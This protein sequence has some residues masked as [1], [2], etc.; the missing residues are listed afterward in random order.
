[1]ATI[2]FKDSDAKRAL[3]SSLFNGKNTKFNYCIQK[4]LKNLDKAREPVIQ[5]YQDKL[6]DLRNK[7]CSVDDKGNRIEATDG[8][9]SFTPDAVSKLAADSKVAADEL[10][11]STIT[12]DPFYA[13]APNVAG[14]EDVANIMMF[15]IEELTGILFDPALYDGGE[16][17]V[18]IPAI[19][20]VEAAKVTTGVVNTIQTEDEVSEKT[21]SDSVIS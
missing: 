21:H 18:P 9:L 2:T 7:Y 11:A 1:M 13:Q 6:N 8:Q 3:I 10:N 20:L 12:F 15:N 19:S 5:T 14:F 4:V 17:I 16:L